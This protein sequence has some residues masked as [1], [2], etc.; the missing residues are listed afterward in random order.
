MKSETVLDV[1]C[2]DWRV[3]VDLSPGAAQ[4]GGTLQELGV[5]PPRCTFDFA[6]PLH[7]SVPVT[8]GTPHMQNWTHVTPR[9][10]ASIFE[11]YF[12]IRVFK[13]KACSLYI[14]SPLFSVFSFTSYS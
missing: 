7:V 4:W 13:D 6:D 3:L 1:D 10:M 12:R 8:E 9:L 14:L 2:R 5:A 11:Q